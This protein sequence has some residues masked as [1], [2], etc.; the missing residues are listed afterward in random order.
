MNEWWGAAATTFTTI[1][2]AKRSNSY[3]QD[4]KEQAEN[5]GETC[6]LCTSF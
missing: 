5:T 1:A 2:A 3:F 4:G 6:V